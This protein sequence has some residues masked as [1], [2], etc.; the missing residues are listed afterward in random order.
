MLGVRAADTEGS[1]DVDPAWGA[2]MCPFTG[3]AISKDIASRGRISYSGLRLRSFSTRKEV[4]AMKHVGENVD[5][6]I[7]GKT[8]VKVPFLEA[9]HGEPKEIGRV[10]ISEKADPRWMD[11]DGCLM[12]DESSTY[13]QGFHK[14]TKVVLEKSREETPYLYTYK[15]QKIFFRIEWEDEEPMNATCPV[16]GKSAHHTSACPKYGHMAI[17]DAHCEHCHFY[18]KP[19]GC[20]YKARPP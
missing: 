13:Y 3:S 14:T 20:Q 1:R 19:Y 16:C 4:A 15:R 5:N 6:S 12:K 17:C 7:Y 11:P 9:V 2:D 8:K 18:K 10:I